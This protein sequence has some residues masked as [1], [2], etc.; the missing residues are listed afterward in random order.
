M[1]QFTFSFFSGRNLSNSG[2]VMT[3]SSFYSFLCFLI[4]KMLLLSFEREDSYRN[5]TKVNTRRKSG[6]YKKTPFRAEHRLSIR[7]FVI[8]MELMQ[9]VV[10][11]ALL[12]AL[13]LVANGS[14]TPLDDYVKAPDPHFAWT[15]ILTY[16][17]PDYTLYILNF[18]SQK[19]LDGKSF[20]R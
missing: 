7:S 5:L 20:D 1:I 15:V 17:Q 13:L 16:N 12:C 9:V 6:R 3:Q 18:T 14:G 4:T 10:R 8:A 11:S 19:W 2:Q